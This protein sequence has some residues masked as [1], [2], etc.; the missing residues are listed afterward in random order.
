MKENKMK[1]ELQ[2]ELAAQAIGTKNPMGRPKYWT[3][4]RVEELGAEITE[5]SKTSDAIILGEFATD[6]DMHPDM[7]TKLARINPVK[8]GLSYKAARRRVGARREKGAIQKDLDPRVYMF[9]ARMYDEQLDEHL[10]KEL[11]EDE[12][13]KAQAKIKALKKELKH[14]GEILDYINGQKKIEDVT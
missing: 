12:L 3:E 6:R 7:L 5:W 13:I 11:A 4:E 14:Q 9:T 2:E 10:K 1:E 8:F